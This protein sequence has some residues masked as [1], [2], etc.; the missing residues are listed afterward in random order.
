M[1][2]AGVGTEVRGQGAK[3]NSDP[4]VPFSVK[5]SPVHPN[6]LLY[7]CRLS[8]KSQVCQQQG[9]VLFVLEHL[10]CVSHYA[11]KYVMI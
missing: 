9:F 6:T 1:T 10:L 3:L 4:C 5:V 8:C 7:T 2:G 11:M